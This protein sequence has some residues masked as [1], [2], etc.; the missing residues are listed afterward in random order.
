VLKP[1]GYLLFTV[2]GDQFLDW[3]TA[4]EAEQY[5]DGHMVVRAVQL[6]G[7]NYCATYHPPEYVSR[8]LVRDCFKVVGFRPGDVAEPFC[9]QDTYLVKKV[10]DAPAV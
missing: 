3:L 7:K 4:A 9:M 2:S 5:R 10:I 1:G 8:E 6:E